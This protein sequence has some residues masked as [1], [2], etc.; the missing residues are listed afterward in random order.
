MIVTVMGMMVYR[1]L[2]PSHSM[3]VR[4]VTTISLFVTFSSMKIWSLRFV[5][6]R[7]LR[8]ANCACNW[9]C[10]CFAAAL[11]YCSKS[12]VFDTVCTVQSRVYDESWMKCSTV[13]LKLFNIRSKARQ[14]QWG[15]ITKI[16]EVG[17]HVMRWYRWGDPCGTY[18]LG[19]HAMWTEARQ[20]GKRG[21][22]EVH[23]AVGMEEGT[24]TGNGREEEGTTSTLT[25][26][27]TDEWTE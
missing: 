15:L 4:V 7:L 19:M 11:F 18:I 25:C 14:K 10:W 27:D 3:L 13:H 20:A 1:I 6:T 12:V 16:I 26:W 2:L 5:A 8:H 21:N 17:D 24:E 22:K 23:E 9:R